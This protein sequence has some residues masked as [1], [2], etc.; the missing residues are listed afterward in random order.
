MPKLTSRPRGASEFER[1]PDGGCADAVIDHGNTL[2]AGDF[3]HPP[4]HVLGAIIDD[5]MAAMVFRHRNFLRRTDRAD[6]RRAERPRPLAQQR[7]DATRGGV[8]ENCVATLHAI[9]R[10]QQITGRH[11]LEHHRRRL[12][13]ADALREPGNLVRGQ[14]PRLGVGADRPG[15]V[16]NA[17]ARL[18]ALHT[19]ANLLDDARRLKAKARGQ[20]HRV[21]A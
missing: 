14:V 16:G 5:V 19:L 4:G 13:I 15:A 7:A 2:A 9:G 1:H 11:A 18:E 21:E 10:A 17:I 20:L 8:H 12:L 6:D 3:A